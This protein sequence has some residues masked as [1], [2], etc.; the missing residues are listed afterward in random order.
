MNGKRF[1]R[2]GDGRDKRGHG[3][4]NGNGKR[5]ARGVEHTIQYTQMMIVYIELY[6]RNL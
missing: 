4:I 2:K 1:I 3:G 5:L 6:T